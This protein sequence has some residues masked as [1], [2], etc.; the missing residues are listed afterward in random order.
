MTIATDW[1]KKITQE[2]IDNAENE[3]VL[4]NCAAGSNGLAMALDIDVLDE[5]ND[6]R[7]LRIIFDLPEGKHQDDMS[8]YTVENIICSDVI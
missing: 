4:V 1:T 5:D 7:I 2:M 6:N 3:A 8:L